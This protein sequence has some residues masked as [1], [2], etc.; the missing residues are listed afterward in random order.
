MTWRT[1]TAFTAEIEYTDNLFMVEESPTSDTYLIGTANIRINGL[2]ESRRL[3][4]DGS[5]RAERLQKTQNAN[6][7]FYSFAI[8]YNEDFRS[9]SF[10]MFT[11]YSEGSTRTTDIETIGILPSFIYGKR[12][13]TTVRPQ[14]EFEANEKNRFS[15]SINYELIRYD[16]NNLTNYTNYQVVS[17]WIHTLNYE[18]RLNTRIIAQRY[19]SLDNSVDHDYGSVLEI[20]DYAASERFQFQIGLG[21]GYIKRE[22]DDNYRT[23]LGRLRGTYQNE[24]SQIY[25]STES[26][27]EPTATSQLTR[28]SLFSIGY[29]REITENRLVNAEI[30]TSRSQLIDITPNYTNDV[31]SFELGYNESLT[32]RLSLVVRYTFTDNKTS[33]DSSICISIRR[34][35]PC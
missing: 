5:V 19:D 9:A 10:S 12:R 31:I 26:S 34:G 33:F 4:L 3:N 7:D 28:L 35:Y 16:L 13:N 11:S 15:F 1:D 24:K 17:D 8:D 32:E 14:I 30:R 2:S 18:T 25:F 21:I 20:I 6:N 27:L 29:R 23:F 22:T